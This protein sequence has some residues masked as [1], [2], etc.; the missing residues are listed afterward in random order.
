M[1]SIYELIRKKKGEAPSSSLDSA[2]IAAD[3]DLKPGLYGKQLT[4]PLGELTVTSLPEIYPDCDWACW[5][6]NGKIA[7]FQMIN[8]EMDHV[9]YED[10][11]DF[12]NNEYGDHISIHDFT[13]DNL[14]NIPFP[15]SLELAAQSYTID[16]LSNLGKSDAAVLSKWRFNLW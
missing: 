11:I 10:N 16:M 7:S 14:L 5:L 6:P 12:S 3:Y 13:Y 15:T 8:G 9:L 1:S 4:I 2:T